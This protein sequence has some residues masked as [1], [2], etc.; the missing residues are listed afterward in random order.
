MSDAA[1][2][3]SP[4]E[5]RADIQQTR[6]HLGATV[7]A[8]AEKT[9]VKTQAQERVQA[10]RTAAAGRFGAARQAVTGTTQRTVARARQATPESAGTGVQQVGSSI[11]QR[12]LPF[13]VAGAFAAGLLIG[14][15]VGHR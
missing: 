9:D 1:Q 7:Q 4:E 10:V 14:W 13:A 15:L 11:Q 12:P 8:L 6:E 2:S 3:R 5:I